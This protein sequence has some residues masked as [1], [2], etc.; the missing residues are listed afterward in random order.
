MEKYFHSVFKRMA[1]FKKLKKIR[2]QITVI[3]M[4]YPCPEGFRV[5][6]TDSWNKA[7]NT[8]KYYTTRREILI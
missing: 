6:F 4:A 1:S 5:F 7:W 3:V 2:V 8:Q